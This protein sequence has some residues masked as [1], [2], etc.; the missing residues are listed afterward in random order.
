MNCDDGGGGGKSTEDQQLEKLQGSW[1]VTSV[2]LDGTDRTSDFSTMV[3]SFTTTA[4]N[5]TF[6]YSIT[7]S[8][9]NP[10]PWPPSGSITL[11]ADPLSQLIRK[12]GSPDLAM[13][14]ALSNADDQLT[15]SFTYTG[16][17][18]AGS[19]RVEA[20]EG[21]WTFVFDKQ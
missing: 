16:A 18:Y 2:D 19:S 17:G 5:T 20:V 14:Y 11:G 8:R 3:M 1:A 21:D 13:T 9:P 4:G 15:I 10:N 12:D 6:G 7:G